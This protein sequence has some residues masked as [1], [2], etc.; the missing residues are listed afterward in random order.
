MKTVTGKYWLLLR[1]SLSRLIVCVLFVFC[2]WLTVHAESPVQLF[3]VANTAYKNK[4]YDLAIEAYTKLLD[5]GYKTSEVYYDLGNAYYKKDQIGQ[6]VLNYEKAHKL[7]PS[8]EDIRY[9]LKLA[10]LKTVDRLIP[11]PRLSVVEKWE[12]FIASRSSHSWAV[13]SIAF[14]WLAL[15]CFAVYLF[16]TIFRRTGF[17]LGLVMLLFA[18]FFGTLSYT[19]TQAEYGADQ[20]ILMTA[21]AYIKS[22]PDAS[23]TDLYMV[24]EGIKMNILDKV[25]EWS[26]V[27]LSDGKVGWIQRTTYAVI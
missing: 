7:A 19:Q 4:N 2:A 21:N 26:K 8:D 13:V 10:N 12:R 18:V 20:A 24:H 15:I 27:R 22:A 6:S 14:V 23:G 3:D 16:V 25:G 9:N 5:Q 1:S 11:V 17:Y